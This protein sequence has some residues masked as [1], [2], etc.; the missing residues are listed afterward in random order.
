ML[1]NSYCTNRLFFSC[2]SFIVSFHSS[3]A[4]HFLFFGILFGYVPY[5]IL[6]ELMVSSIHGTDTSKFHLELQPMFKDY[7]NLRR[8]PISLKSVLLYVWLSRVPGV[9]TGFWFCLHCIVCKAFFP[10]CKLS[11]I[12]KKKSLVV[13]SF[14]VSARRLYQLT[15]WFYWMLGE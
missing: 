12:T 11:S 4:F 6:S 13:S 3:S 15:D 8:C 5:T 9:A 1:C 7:M 10:S 2:T 14:T